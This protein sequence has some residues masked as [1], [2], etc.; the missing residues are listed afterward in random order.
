M[1]RVLLFT[2]KGGVGKTTTAAA[3]ALRCAD[4]GLRTIVM[5]TDPAHSLADA[6]DVDLGPLASPI[7]VSLWGQ[8]LDA[9]ERMEDSWHDI[10]G[11]L[12]EV[13]AWAGVEGIEAEELSVVPGL[14]EVFALADI[15]QYAD[16]GE[17]DVVV[18]DCAPTAETI[19]FLSL[20]DI[21]SRYMERLFPVGRRVNKLVSP[22]LA[23]VTS[24]PVAGDDVFAATSAFYERL[25]GVREILMDPER[26]SVRLVVNPER[27]VIAE[28]RRTFTYLSLFGYRVDAV[29]ANRLLPDAIA[30]PWFERWKELHTEHLRT[31]EDGFAPLPVL[32]AELAP[33]ELVGIDALR[34]F[35][36]ELYGDLD[37]ASRLHD[38]EPLRITRRG[39]RTT[40]S[41]ELPFADREDLEL[42]RRGDELLVRVGP[43]RRAITLPD[44]L[45]NRAVTGASLKQGRLKVVFEGRAHGG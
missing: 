18:V 21:L 19:R 37:A 2:G 10:Q 17:W 5:S 24:L 23:R 6:F 33:T 30:D 40:M 25:D 43:Y 13:F 22:L 36:Q 28:A 44:S 45:R 15:K 3:T 26:T 34:G 35:G 31:I 27:M 8:Q 9:Q 38:G 20:P 16:S 41:I 39:D 4:A 29:V 7:T 42:G 32:K 12:R 14:D 11:W 1:T